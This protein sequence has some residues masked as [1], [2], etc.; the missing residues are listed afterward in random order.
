[1]LEDQWEPPD[2][3]AEPLDDDEPEPDDD[4]PEL[5]RVRRRDRKI[6]EAKAVLMA[7]VFQ[8]QAE[9]VFYERQIEVLYERRFFHWITGRALRELTGEDAVGSQ[10]LPLQGPINVRFYWSKGLRYWKRQADALRR[11]ILRYSAQEFTRALGQQGETLFDAALPRGGFMPKARNVREYGGRGWD[12][13]AHDLDRVFDKD[14]ISYG[15]EIKNTLVYIARQELTVKL[16]MCR[17]LGLRPLFIVRAAPK[18]YIHRVNQAGGYV[19]MFGWQLYPFG[20]EDFAREV[21]GRLGLPVDC[22]RAIEDGTI[23]RLVTWH[24]RHPAGGA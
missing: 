22:P 10:L 8:A 5:P 13:T 7:E 19:L 16:G 24:T 17:L 9:R 2:Y 14:G 12:L 1:M 3:E 20:Y 18:S 23:Q 21:H 6:D 4:E 11:L 15:V